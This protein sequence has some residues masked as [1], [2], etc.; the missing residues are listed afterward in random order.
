MI[1]D[2]FESSMNFITGPRQPS[3]II[4]ED[5]LAACTP[6]G[7]IGAMRD[8]AIC[9]GTPI[10]DAHYIGHDLTVNDP[11]LSQFIRHELESPFNPDPGAEFRGKFK[12]Q[13]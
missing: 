11:P 7:L 5:I 8:R 9:L 3:Q 4:A 2:H 13:L 10:H 12:L 1:S 6:S